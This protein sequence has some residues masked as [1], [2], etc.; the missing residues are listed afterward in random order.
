MLSIRVIL[1]LLFIISLLFT[2]CT[3]QFYHSDLICVGVQAET[4]RV[5][6][7]NQNPVLGADITIINKRTGKQ[8]CV[9][10]QGVVDES[11]ANAIGES[12]IQ[13]GDYIL[14]SI[15]NTRHTEPTADVQHLDIIEA[16]IEKNGVSV[17]HTYIVELDSGRCYPENI[18]GPRLVTLDLP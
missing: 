18:E 4:I 10:K 5:V 2:A 16:T 15:V 3:D 9:D 13:N 8:F 17:T 12:D 7:Q 11:C 6:D 14:V 1:P